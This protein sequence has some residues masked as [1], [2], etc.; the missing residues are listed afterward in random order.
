MT[1][2]SM[3]DE[4]GILILGLGMMGGSLAAALKHHGYS[5]V[6]RGCDQQEDDIALGQQMG[7]I[8]GGGTDPF[9]LLD[10]ISMIVLCVPVMAIAPWVIKLA[11]VVRARNIIVTDVGSSKGAVRDAV[12]AALGEMPAWLVLGHPI[13]GSEHSGVAAADPKRYVANKVI[14]TPES[15]TPSA[16]T[17]RVASLWQAAG[18]EVVTMSVRRHD[19]VLARTSHL[20]H[21]L[22]FSLVDTL[23]HQDERFDIFRYAA[24]GF[25]DFTRI[26]G[27]DPVMWRDIFLSN[28][29]AVLDALDD[30]EAGLAQLREAIDESDADALHTIFVRASRARQHFQTLLDKTTS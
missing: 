22:A 15:D 1:C 29:S 17:A 3:L 21:L 9:A 13:A 10:G 7:I 27:S 24:G 19:D 4:A 12:V 16:F 8:D 20:P 5:G 23:A 14:L 30:F 2:K 18:A 11:P 6:I 25:R 26:A 28:R